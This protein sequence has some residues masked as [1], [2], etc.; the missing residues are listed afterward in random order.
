M[1]VRSTSA[2]HQRDAQDAVQAQSVESRQNLWQYGLV[3][4]LIVL[5]MESAVG[6]P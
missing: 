4:M 1:V 6:R 5:V 2:A 3:L